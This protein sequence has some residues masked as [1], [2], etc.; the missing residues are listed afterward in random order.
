VSCGPMVG[1]RSSSFVMEPPSLWSDARN[2][3]IET[4]CTAVQTLRR[5]RWA[6]HVVRIGD[7][8]NVY[9]ILFGKPEAKRPLG[10][11]TRR[12]EDNIRVDLT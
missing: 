8:R 12:C 5:M 10:K 2:L 1:N 9:K 6:G 3:V 4:F 11:L 7:M